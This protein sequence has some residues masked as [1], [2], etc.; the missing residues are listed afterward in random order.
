[1]SHDLGCHGHHF[2][3]KLC[4][5]IVAKIGILLDW[6]VAVLVKGAHNYLTIQYIKMSHIPLECCRPDSFPIMY[7]IV[8]ITLY[9]VFSH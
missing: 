8:V 6:L 3:G 9:D 7:H 5:T 1:M 4:V 2:G